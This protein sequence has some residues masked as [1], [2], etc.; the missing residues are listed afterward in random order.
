M[1]NYY[2]VLGVPQ[3]A[4]AGEIKKAYE[5]LAKQYDPSQN[6]G[7]KYAE[8]RFIDISLA[9]KTLIDVE[10]RKDYDKVLSGI[11]SQPGGGEA[12]GMS[13]S[14]DVKRINPSVIYIVL[15]LAAV[16]VTAIIMMNTH[17]IPLKSKPEIV[18]VDT[19]PLQSQ[20]LA[21]DTVVPAVAVPAETKVIKLD[22]AV[23]KEEKVVK[24]DTARKVKQVVVAK[25]VPKKDTV[26]TEPKVEPEPQKPAV[27]EGLFIGATKSHVL[28]VQG[29]PTSI[30]KY[31][32]KSEMWYYGKSTIYFAGNTMSAYKNVDNNLKL[33]QSN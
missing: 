26:K 29:T 27:A 20:S 22:T 10:K 3:T 1:K 8:E 25:P 19:A 14:K 30:I 18:A 15:A 32:N 9:Y 33:M 21:V 2:K 7:D 16:V 5:M 13:A 4:S 11:Q 28:S 24:K 6:R 23:R 17:K 31:E 12:I